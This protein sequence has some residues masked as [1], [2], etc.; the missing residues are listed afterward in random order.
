MGNT[1]SDTIKTVLDESQTALPYRIH[2]VHA[3]AITLIIFVSRDNKIKF[4]LEEYTSNFWKK[5]DLLRFEIVFFI[6][7]RNKIL[8]FFIQPRFNLFAEFLAIFNSLLYNWLIKNL[9]FFSSIN[10]LLTVQEFILK[11]NIQ[12]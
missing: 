1:V 12:F 7:I 6:N 10:I 8:S 3:F 5:I 11:V 9:I 4:M 2:A